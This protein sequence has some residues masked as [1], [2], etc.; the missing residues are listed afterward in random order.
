MK[1]AFFQYLPIQFTTHFP[2]QNPWL[3]EIVYANSENV[4][5][6]PPLP[7]DDE[8][9]T[10]VLPMENKYTYVYSIININIL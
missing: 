10:L 2:L 9:S 8:K 6:R 7:N 5:T 3:K 1:Q 4:S